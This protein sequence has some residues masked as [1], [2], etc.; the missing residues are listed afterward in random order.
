MECRRSWFVLS[1]L[2]LL[3]GATFAVP[4]NLT[5]YGLGSS[6]RARA[7]AT[8][9]TNGV[10]PL[11]AGV[12]AIGRPI[13]SHAT[14]IEPS[15][16]HMRQPY[17]DTGGARVNVEGL[18]AGAGSV[19]GAVGD[20]VYV[21]VA[22]GALAIYDKLRGRRQFGPAAVAGVFAGAGR[23][24]AM[25]ACRLQNAHGAVILHDGPAQRWIVSYRVA[26]RDQL[27][28]PS[29]YQCI[30]VSA[31]A[32]AAGAYYRY[33]IEM[34]NVRGGAQYFDDP[35]LAIWPGAFYLTFNLFEGAAGRFLG[36]RVC[37]LARQALLGGA[38][39]AMRC[40]DA[41]NAVGALTPATWSGARHP[42]G[43]PPVALL[44]LGAGG[45]SVQL[46][47]FAFSSARFDRAVTLPVAPFAT[48]GSETLIGQSPPG[49]GLAPMADRFAPQA[50]YHQDSAKPS[51]LANHSVR[52][53]D[54][55]VGIRWYQIG[56]ALGA[57]YVVQQGTLGAGHDSRWM[58]A[59]GGDRAG[60]IAIGYSVAAPDSGPGFRYTGRSVG[61]RPS[62][63]QTE[64]IIVNGTGV[65]TQ[66]DAI[67]RADGSLTLDP[68]DGCTFWATQR[69]VAVTGGATWR[70][71]IASFRF[72][73]CP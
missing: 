38:D 30:A 50:V 36:A 45:K 60:N 37:G 40:R 67:S 15:H 35:K 71:R 17:V 8:P 64:E 31:G 33:A 5:A 48:A 3:S 52:L 11:D 55:R 54:G 16:S 41:G 23:S 22:D 61:D 21:Q 58:G 19:S 46:L 7:A 1:V 29:Y 49:A 70:T 73:S 6:L 4:G 44:S 56:A 14:H 32:D 62:T 53:P 13:E 72:R 66:A 2:Y 68:A 24:A 9:N 20:A 12:R 69:Y 51:L 26:E 18:P 34:K 47:R 10:A 27:A 57:A 42:P 39:A 63:M 65:D 25:D 43:A 28:R 59:I